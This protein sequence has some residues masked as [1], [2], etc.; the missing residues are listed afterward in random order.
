[1]SSRNIGKLVTVSNRSIIAE[2]YDNLGNYI[3]TTDGIRF[4][5]EISSYIT[6]DD[7]GIKIIAEVVGVDEKT[8]STYDKM[9]KPKSAKFIFLSLI[10]EIL[11]GK[12][13][14]GVSKMPLIFSTIS[15]ITDQDLK[16]RFPKSVT[17]YFVKNPLKPVV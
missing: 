3:N 11:N 12:F 1:M 15:I 8:S 2:M 7:I 17:S 13:F 9:S 5:G 14:F 6:I 16:P 4:V 10:G